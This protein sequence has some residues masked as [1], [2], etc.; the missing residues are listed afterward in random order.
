MLQATILQ[1]L[2]TFKRA[3]IC[4]LG[5]SLLIIV[6][7]VNGA[8]AQVQTATISGTV[9]DS[10]GAVIPGA[11]IQVKNAATGI[12]QTATADD[13]GRYRMADLPVGNYEV[14]A[15]LAGFQTV[16]RQGII[17]TVGSQPVV[18]FSLPVGNTTESVTI[19]SQVSPVETQTSSVSSLVTQ[20]QIRDLPL[21]G[22][23][24]EQLLTLGPGVQTVPQS[25]A[26]GGG[27]ATFYGQ[28]TNYSVSGSRPVGQAFLLDN[29]DIQGFFE[30]GA[31][32]AVTG[33]SLGIEAIREFQV[34][35]NTY[36][37]Q[38]GGT[39]AVVNAVSRSG[40]NEWHGSGF[41]FLRNSVFDAKNF[42]D[43]PSSPIPSFRR[44]QFGGTLG[45]PVKTDKLFFFINYEGLRQSQGQ[46]GRQFVPDANV[47][48]GLL[49]C[50]A[51]NNLTGCTASTQDTSFGVPNPN[52]P[53]P[54][55]A[56]IAKILPL[57]PLPNAAPAPGLPVGADL[58]DALGRR[59]G[60]GLFTSVA[61]QI[62]NENY[63]LGRIDYQLSG[64]D[65]LF[66]RYVLD[67]ANQLIPF[68]LSLVNK[69]PEAD[70][71]ANQY[72]TVEERRVFS[73]QVVNSARFSFVRTNERAGTAGETPALNLIG[74]GRQDAAINA[75]GA[76]GPV[77]PIGA[78]GTVPFFLVQNKFTVGDDISWVHGPHSLQ[79]GAAIVRVQTNLS[80]PF[81]V[82]GNFTFGTLENFLNGTP[83]SMLGMSA[84]TPDF[85]TNRY[86]REIDIFPYVQDDWKL[87]P[88]LTLN[89]GLRYDYA[90]N[91]TAVAVP[92][93]AI[94]N[95]LT[96][97]GF[98]RVDHV[99]ASNPNV[100][101]FDPRIGLAWDP[102]GDH[103]TSIRAG[104]GIFH[105]PVA[106]RTYAP[107]YYLAP[108]SGATILVN[109]KLATGL[110]FLPGLSL[111]NPY[112]LGLPPGSAFTVPYVAFAGINYHT[113]T[114]PYV[115]QYNLTIQ[116]EI[117]LGIVASAGYV[118]SSG[119]HL[120]SERDMNLT[121]G[122]AGGSGAIG[123]L[124]NPFS[125]KETNP[126]F[127]SLN[128]VAAS[129]HSTYHSLQLALNRQFGKGLV[130]QG[131]Y[132]W[133]KCIDDGS[134]SS[135]LEQGAFEVTDA[136]NQNYD[137]GPCAFNIGQS[138][139][140]SSVYAL[141]F[142]GNRV[143]EG[144]QVSGI[145]SATS[146]L[147]INIQTGFTFPTQSNLQGIQGDRPS[148]SGVSGCNPSQVV[149]R[150]DQWFNPACYVLQPFGTLGG[151]SRDSINGPGLF[152]LDMAL[153]KQTRISE[154]LDTQ[155]RFEIFNL[156]NHP[157]FGQPVNTLFS[158]SVSS[159]IPNPLAGRITSTST[160]SRQMQFGLK[161]VF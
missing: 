130:L 84:P 146:G 97:T 25:A 52:N 42:F 26:G 79:A 73:P 41:E 56:Q 114:S 68:P 95:P 30:H 12:I 159:P 7:G 8:N 61:N 14:Q 62:A 75:T 37:A 19:V 57:Y 65:S 133:S 70:N 16:L 40:T 6:A 103:K 142:S 74:A 109:L 140:L 131:S 135:G 149:G 58:V 72:F 155:F 100:H 107:A 118:G 136:H 132:T 116:R 93:F 76:A 35:T 153:L 127:S 78:N 55:L 46:T 4:V 64:N 45:G 48:N 13:Q 17:L 34:L 113:D 63:V 91:A 28:E 144:W 82:G 59:T 122:T 88:R 129:S 145:L 148:Y 106:P 47:H 134:V 147:P 99:L 39:G 29:T 83:A 80:A 27:S 11:T 126:N 10:S 67:R 150:A 22:R 160:P 101:N 38:F 24:F 151:V 49:P 158:G 87:T 21:N 111:T 112:G 3:S 71:S 96:S 121:Q 157:N 60:V 5:A 43:D 123:S 53:N 117:G 125:G 108:P 138:F 32:S 137:R 85:S 90:T 51:R 20:T 94:L 77:T 9:T 81:N 31:G 92:L 128:G 124:T 143:V 115:M 18:D 154:K 139:R 119:V 33:N 54:D 110:P 104:F 36:S 152:N 15:S 86:F 141:P 66:G 161:L 69:W 23:N 44:N 1:S 156:P 2:K 50:A 98:T 102:F 89:L 120:F 105:E